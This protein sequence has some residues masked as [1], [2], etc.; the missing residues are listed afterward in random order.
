MSKR[1]WTQG[2]IA[3]LALVVSAWLAGA[4]HA[5]P[6]NCGNN[7]TDPGETC[8]DGNTVSGDGCASNCLIEECGDGVLTP[9][10]EECDDGNTVGDDGCDATCNLEC[11]NGTLEGAEE[12]DTSGESATCDDDCT[13][14]VCGDGNLNESAGEECDDTNTTSGDGCS[15]TCL[16]ETAELDPKE[17]GCANALNGNFSKVVKAQDKDNASCVK[18]TAKSGG[19]V[20][21]CVG[22]DLAGKVAK[23]QAKTTAT[24]AGK[25]CT[26][27]G[28]CTG[29]DDFACKAGATAINDAGENEP[30]SAF[31]FIFGTTPNIVMKSADKA[32]ASCQAEA[33]KRWNKLTETWVAEFNKAVKSL[34]KGS[35]STPPVANP[36]DLAAGVDTAIAASTK[37]TKA[38]N[39]VNSGIANKCP[40]A[41]VDGLFDC[42]AATTGNA[43]AVCVIA[44][45]K[46]AACQ[47]AEAANG[48]ALTCPDVLP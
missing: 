33:L 17:Q 44:A 37:I 30:I 14:V 18:T 2:F 48:L 4:A 8:D 29:T 24:E 12:C 43:L 35:K 23:A 42:N 47:A 25:K 11:G 7:V 41:I 32:G 21:A 22:A 26:G 31:T 5:G 13:N 19:D 45:A 39:G 27:D 16:L 38:E 28:D 36:T 1:I 34:L 10:T 46:D 20:T 6:N 9:D 40:D 3:A 15:A